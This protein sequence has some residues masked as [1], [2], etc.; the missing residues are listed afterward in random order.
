M[1]WIVI[2]DCELKW[3]KNEKHTSLYED[4]IKYGLAEETP[5]NLGDP[6]EW[7]TITG[8]TDAPVSVDTPVLKKVYKKPKA[9]KNGRKADPQ[10]NAEP[11]QIGQI[12][13]AKYEC[14][15]QKSRNSNYHGFQIGMVGYDHFFEFKCVDRQQ[16]D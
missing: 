9:L 7:F 15:V 14:F 3:Y 6:S 1:Y 8:M 5:Q 13:F 4:K 11:I 2:K 12:N 10:S 16:F